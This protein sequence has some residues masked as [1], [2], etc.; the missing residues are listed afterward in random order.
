M[1]PNKV[2]IKIM[3]Y[4]LI[5]QYK[6]FTSNTLLDLLTLLIFGRSSL[7]SEYIENNSSYKLVTF[8]ENKNMLISWEK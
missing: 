2:S 8:T 4:L 5:L 3:L 6:Y 1:K 7:F